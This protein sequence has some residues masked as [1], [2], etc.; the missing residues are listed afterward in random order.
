MYNFGNKDSI[1][2]PGKADSVGGFAGWKI[3]LLET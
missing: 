2:D 3:S 1:F